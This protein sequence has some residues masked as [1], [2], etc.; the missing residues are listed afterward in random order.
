[1]I[2]ENRFSEYK[3]TFFEIQKDIQEDQNI[4]TPQKIGKRIKLLAGID[5]GKYA[6]SVR[7]EEREIA[8]TSTELIHVRKILISPKEMA[9]IFVL[10]DEQLLSIFI[11]FAIDLETV[12]DTDDNVSIVEIYNRYLY[13]Q[14]MFKVEKQ[15]VLESTIK[16]LINELHIL[17]TYM[18]PKY[19][20]DEA[21]RG[22]V[23]SESDHKDFAYSDAIW[24]EAKAINVGK[25]TVKIS[26]IEQLQAN[27]HGVL[28][29]SELEKTSSENSYGVRLFD[30]INRIKEK[31]ELEDVE[32]SFLNKISSIGFSLDIISDP[33]HE[34]NK[35]RYIIHNVR[36]YSVDDTFPRIKREDLPSAIGLVS[37]ELII[38]EIQEKA[39]DFK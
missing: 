12:I 11:A 38:A 27:S 28:I 29:I 2:N 25:V 14:K 35:S 9:T 30:Q 34:A 16:G 31:I 6:I 17:E 13:W 15:Q 37:Y 22:W 18:F 10:S 32:L 1:M 19:G 4:F 3:H 5:Q 8:L 21:V 24:Y 7:S 23:G 39:I 33:N 26:S 20:S 36:F